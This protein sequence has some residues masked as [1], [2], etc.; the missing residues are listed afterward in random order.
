MYWENPFRFPA[1]KGRSLIVGLE[2][3]ADELLV[4]TG[5]QVQQEAG[6]AASLHS[7]GW[8]AGKGH[9]E[10]AP[11]LGQAAA[12]KSWSFRDWEVAEQGLWGWKF[13]P[14]LPVSWGGAADSQS[15]VT[16]RTGCARAL[17]PCWSGFYSITLSFLCL[18]GSVI[19]QG[20]VW[21]GIV[22][23]EL[24]CVCK[25]LW[26]CSLYSSGS[27]TQGKGDL[28]KT[29]HLLTLGIT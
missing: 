26:W 7:K 24:Q 13:C 8:A 16:A 25:L 21:P 23:R 6:G 3:F 20:F 15:E 11:S 19:Q 28:H 4:L 22:C 12:D 27:L 18:W 2:G 5:S 10:W 17:N 1:N 14:C 9:G 29:F